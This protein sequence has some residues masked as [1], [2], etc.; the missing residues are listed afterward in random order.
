[1]SVGF[2]VPAAWGPRLFVQSQG[3]GDEAYLFSGVC[4]PEGPLYVASESSR[5]CGPVFAVTAL[6][7]LC[8]S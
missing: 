4:V 2:S 1:M 7:G 8:A 3:F 6:P 5:L